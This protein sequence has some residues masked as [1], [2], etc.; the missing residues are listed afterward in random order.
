MK[1]SLFRNLSRSV[2][3]GECF[4]SFAIDRCRRHYFSLAYDFE[5]CHRDLVDFNRRTKLPVGAVKS[6]I[7]RG[8]NRLAAVLKNRS[9]LGVF[10]IKKVPP[11]EAHGQARF[12]FSLSRRIDCCHVLAALVNTDSKS[13]LFLLLSTVR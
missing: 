10:L 5:L 1:Y 13:S 8:G 11:R 4:S 12:N 7:N 3:Y 6:V 9:S 2:L